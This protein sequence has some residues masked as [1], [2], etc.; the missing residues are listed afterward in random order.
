MP[1]SESPRIATGAAAYVR[2]HGG[3]GKYWG[4]YSDER[5]LEWADWMLDQ[6]RTSRPV[7]AYFNND[8]E[9]HAIH[10]AQTLRAMISQSVTR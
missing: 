5:L 6:A 8:A 9:A 7:W 10:D 1:G 3:E 2:F 4:R